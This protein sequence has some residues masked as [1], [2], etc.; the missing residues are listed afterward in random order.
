M[1][2]ARPS[3]STSSSSNPIYFWRDIEDQTGWLS[4]WYPC[5]FTDDAGRLY[6]TA[7]YYMMYHKAR[8]F[9][10]IGTGNSILSAG[11][12]RKAKSLGRQVANFDESVLAA[13]CQA[14]VRQGNHLKFMP[15]VI[16]ESELRRGASDAAP[17]VGMTLREL[18]L[19]TGDRELVEAIP[20]DNIWGVGFTALDAEMNREHCGKNLPGKALMEVR[21]IFKEDE[22]KKTGDEK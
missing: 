8:L 6:K 9:S 18:L 12:P 1:L 7:E 10:D 19:S 13:E 14:I 16:D 20:F 3:S 21:E 17:L 22:N 2:N 15:P 4:Q 5:A 11:N